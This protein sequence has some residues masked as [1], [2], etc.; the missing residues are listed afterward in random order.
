MFSQSASEVLYVTE[1]FK[2][3]PDRIEA[4]YLPRSDDAHHLEGCKGESE[5]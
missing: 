3:F 2:G 4:L 1:D 5:D